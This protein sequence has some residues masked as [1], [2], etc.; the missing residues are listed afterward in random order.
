MRL[1]ERVAMRLG[2]V[3]G[4]LA[5]FAYARLARALVRLAE[6]DPDRVVRVSHDHLAALVGT[7]RET[8]TTALHQLQRLGLVKLS[9]RSVHVVDPHGLEQLGA[10]WPSRYSG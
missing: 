1:F 10:I 2:D 5:P 3:E 6:Q 8:I 9:R 4:A 7:Y